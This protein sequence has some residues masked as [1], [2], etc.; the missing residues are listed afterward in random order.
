MKRFKEFKSEQQY[1]AEVGPIGAALMGAMGLFGAWKAFKGV[2]AKIKGYK[3]SSAEKKEN[4]KEGFSIRIKKFNPETGKEESEIV[5][6][7]PGDKRGNVDADG[8][9]K[10]EKEEQKTQDSLNKKQASDWKKKRDELGMNHKDYVDHL[11]KD[12]KSAARKAA[13][14]TP[15]PVG[16]ELKYKVF[17]R[18]SGELID[19]TEPSTKE[20]FDDEINDYIQQK[21]DDAKKQ[22]DDYKK[23]QG[24]EDEPTA[25]TAS[26]KTGD[27][28]TGDDDETT[29]DDPE[30]ILRSKGDKPPEEGGIDS[31]GDANAYL[32][33]VGKAPNGWTQ[34]KSKTGK[35]SML[36][37]KS[38]LPKKPNNKPDNKGFVKTGPATMKKVYNSNVLKFGEFITEDL[39]KDLKLASK[40]RK[41]SEITL[42]DGTDIPMDAFTAEIL[43][44]Y[45]EGLS[46]SEKNKTIKQFQRTERAF[47]KVLGKAH[48]G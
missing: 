27:D 22:L 3:E 2:K 24:V 19:K 17:D 38:D 40:S 25:N 37:K 39:M 20:M 44:K 1:V 33:L 13:G 42:D 12:K 43:V 21:N 32:K 23:A 8:I 47:M 30:E 10:L 41:D 26:P 29:E 4:K 16:K 34:Q 28:E 15:N 46:S 48:E 18:E 11:A 45:I 6:I 7:P 35:S 5:D 9:L 31:D 14:E 36:V